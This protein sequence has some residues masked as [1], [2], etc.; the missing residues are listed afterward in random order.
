MDWGD[1]PAWGA[2]VLAAGALGV[3]LKARGDGKR[4]AD[5]A[6]ASVTEARR[7]AAAA[8]ASVVDGRR[9]ADAA[10]AALAEQR[11]EAE[12]RRAAEAEAAAPKVAMVL[13]HRSRSRFQ[14]A[15]E[16]TAPA[17]N[18]HFAEEIPTLIGNLPAGLTLGPGEVVDF[19][20]AG[21]MVNAIPPMVLVQWDGQE[22]PV[23]LRVP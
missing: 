5:A 14:L 10:E 3:A 2:L 9:S 19:M 17:H 7:S 15:N 23:P 13:H 21:D 11:R 12:E 20:M 4:S 22:A 8:E 18:V 6:Q 1:A 16:G